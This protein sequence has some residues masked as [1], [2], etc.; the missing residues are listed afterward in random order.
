M[1][2]KEDVSFLSQLIK[3]L[4][5]AGIKLEESYNSKDYDSFNKS[6]RLMLQIQKQISER[7]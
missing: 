4:E 6:K 7:I 5:E 3:S 1:I 2:K